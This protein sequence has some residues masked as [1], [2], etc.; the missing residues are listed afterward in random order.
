MFMMASMICMISA[1]LVNYA[2][3]IKTHRE[4]KSKQTKFIALIVNITAFVISLYFYF[5]HNYY[6]EPGGNENFVF[7]C[8]LVCMCS[9]S[10][11]LSSTDHTT[12]TL[13]D[14]IRRVSKK[15]RSGFDFFLSTTL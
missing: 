1:C 11:L 5:R 10:S 9:S 14:Q 3:V 12:L 7:K 15:R 13:K 2:T 6:C 8:V 4:V